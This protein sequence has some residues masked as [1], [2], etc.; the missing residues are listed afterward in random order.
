MVEAKIDINKYDVRELGLRVGL[1]LHQQ[2]DTRHKLF[3]SCPTVLV[4][5]E[6][7]TKFIRQLRPTRSE[8]GEVDV[9]ALFEWQRKRLYVYE[10]PSSSSCLVEDD[11]EPPHELNRDAVVI[12]LAMA[13]AFK[14]TIVDEVHVMRKIVIDGSNTTGFQRTA[15]VALG[16]SVPI[17]GKNI[18][19][20]SIAVE[21]DAARKISEKANKVIY[22][23]DRLG[24]PLIEISTEPDMTTPEEVYETALT[25]GLMLRLTGRV[26][27]GLGTIRQDLNVSIKNGVRTEIKGV[28]RLDLLPKIVLY[29]AIRQARLLEIREE[30]L[31]RGVKQQDILSQRITD[32]TG[33]LSQSKSKIIK[34]A[35]QRGGVVYAIKLPG[36][37][38]I[39]GAEVQPGRRFGTELADYAR[40]WG[41]VG[42]I[43]H[44]DELPGY[45]ISPSEVEAIY[46]ALRAD[47][48]KDAFVIVA[49]SREKAEKALKAVK[50][51]AA[52]ALQ[53][54]PRETRAALEDGT[55]KYSRPQ[56]GA[57]RM[58]PETDIPPLEIS[59]ELISRAEKIKPVTPKEKLELLIRDYKLNEQLASQ[60]LRSQYLELFEVLAKKYTSIPSSLI[61]SIFTSVLRNL[62]R[63]GIDVERI[64]E[65]AFDEI[66]RALANKE[67]VKEAIPEIL[68]EIASKGISASDAI[69]RHAAQRISESDIEKIVEEA[70]ERLGDEVRVKGY[71]ALNKIMGYVM[72]KLRGKVDGKIVAQIA[73]NKIDEMLRKGKEPQ[74]E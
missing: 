44:S 9:A 69:K 53:G 15:I 60:V 11:E 8:L 64:P 35:L 30:L 26:K 39:L 61:A 43:F 47:P 34:R 10:A 14:S 7:M 25:I 19:I 72:Q 54:I 21:E 46:K 40:F 4:E 31:N 3:C 73:R 57:A 71:R 56:P 32:I 62:K 59:P 16:G 58:Y 67:I 24:I 68:S 22:R 1:E 2:L 50:W 13:M 18:G 41:G 17:N 66:L 33:L 49:D 12:A 36:F 38:G 70:I 29:E 48:G 74:G 23:L 6:S 27:R 45:G 20:Q 55:T 63:E 65:E 42:G 52:Y 5:N 37:K 28:Q 51:R